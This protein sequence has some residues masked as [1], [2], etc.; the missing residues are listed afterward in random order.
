MKKGLK[1]IGTIIFIILLSYIIYRNI[2][3]QTIPSVDLIKDEATSSLYHG[4]LPNTSNSTWTNYYYSHS[5]LTSKELPEE[6]K[7]NIAYKNSGTAM[8]FIDEKNIKESYEKIFGPNTYQGIDQFSDG[9][10]TYTYDSISSRYMKITTNSCT[11]SNM[12]ILSKIVDAK[13]VKDKMEITVVI[14]YLDQTK[15]IVYKDCNEDMTSCKNKLVENF[16]NFDEADLEKEKEELHK[17]QFTFFN[18]Q[19]EYYFESVKKIK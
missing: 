16:E 14:A 5:S 4:V 2:N 17:Y 7:Y 12:Y 6:I 9:C 1:I 15:K 11:P 19:D 8:S 13:Y 10:N 3:L 18:E